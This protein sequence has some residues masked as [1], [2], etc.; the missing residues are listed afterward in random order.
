MNLSNV[1]AYHFAV[2]CVCFVFM[3]ALILTGHENNEAIAVVSLVLGTVFGMRMNTTSTAGDNPNVT[4]PPVLP[5]SSDRNHDP[6]HDP[7]P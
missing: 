6:G 1:N 3:G 2:L 7:L 5:A 4:N